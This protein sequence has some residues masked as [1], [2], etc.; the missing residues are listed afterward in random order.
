MKF[1]RQ[2]TKQSRMRKATEEKML[3]STAEEFKAFI[4]ENAICETEEAFDK[5]YFYPYG[6]SQSV[7]GDYYE[8]QGEE[9]AGD[10]F[11]ITDDGRI[12]YC[13]SA[14]NSIEVVDELGQENEMNKMIN[15][16]VKAYKDAIYEIRR[17]WFCG[18]IQSIAEVN[19]LLEDE[20]DTIN[21]AFYALT[22]YEIVAHVEIEKAQ[23]EC[24]SYMMSKLVH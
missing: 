10:E 12:F 14:M 19:K 5:A 20:Y 13:E 7:T 1:N 23:A 22:K 2:I 17:D 18:R 15:Q 16:M 6:E 9:F 11:I 24:F 4:L 3:A 21:D 8:M